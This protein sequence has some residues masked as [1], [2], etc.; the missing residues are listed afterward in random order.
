MIERATQNAREVI[1]TL[2]NKSKLSS[3]VLGVNLNADVFALAIRIYCHGTTMTPKL[4]ACA[5]TLLHSPSR[6]K[7]LSLISLCLIL[8][9][10]YTCF[11]LTVPTCPI[12]ELP[13]IAVVGLA[14][15][16]APSLLFF[17][18]G[19]LP[20]PRTLFFFIP[21]QAAAKRREA[22]GGVR[23]SNV[24]ER[25]GRTVTRAGIGVPGM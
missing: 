3:L 13:A 21:T 17:G 19:T 7:P 10:S 2:C 25:S 14:L 23:S 22:V 1:S 11:K 15:P 20:A 9:I 12:P 5:T 18:P 4:P 24:K 8:A 6:L 16:C